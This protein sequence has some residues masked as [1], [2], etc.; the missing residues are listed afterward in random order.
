MKLNA[1]Y[2]KTFEELIKEMDLVDM[3]VHTNETGDVCCIELKYYPVE[4]K[5]NHDEKDPFS[6]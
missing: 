2:K 4:P 3:K 6:F 1:V 5:R